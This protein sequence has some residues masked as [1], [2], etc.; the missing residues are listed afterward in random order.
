[1]HSFTDESCPLVDTAERKGP[2]GRVSPLVWM[3]FL[4]FHAE[5]SMESAGNAIKPRD[6]SAPLLPGG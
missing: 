1:M 3:S 2:W 4:G 6:V 5:Q